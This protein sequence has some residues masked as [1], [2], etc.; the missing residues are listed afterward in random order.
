MSSHHFVK[1]DQE[2]ALLILDAEAIPFEQIQELLEWSPTIIADARAL[3]GVLGW[4]IKF[5]VVVA[6]QILVEKVKSELVHYAPVKVIGYPEG[7]SAVQTAFQFIAATRQKFVH[8]VCTSPEA[9]FNL[10]SFITNNLKIVVLT[11][12][13]RWV[14]N[15]SGHY[16]KWLPAG[17]QVMV[18][19]A[20][21][22]KEVL[23]AKA[24]GILEISKPEKFWIGEQL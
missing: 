13:M 20:A 24:D 10:E 16:Q 3:K 18:S 4:G 23:T 21:H 8:V 17:T 12:G 1:E 5:D 6:E 15:E 9:I 14:F 11:N 7:D 19:T 22:K 2:P